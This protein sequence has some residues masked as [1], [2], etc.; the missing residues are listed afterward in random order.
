MRLW[1]VL[2]IAAVLLLLV[3]RS[4]RRMEHAKVQAEMSRYAATRGVS[5]YFLPD[6]AYHPPVVSGD[7]P[8][9]YFPPRRYKITPIPR[10]ENIQPITPDDRAK[11]VASYPYPIAD[12]V[13]NT[14]K[15]PAFA[16]LRI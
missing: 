9:Q 13:R 4:I 11:D 3:F 7:L 15:P 8:R 10:M 6:L 1:I 12:N 2:V 16:P 5:E 14:N